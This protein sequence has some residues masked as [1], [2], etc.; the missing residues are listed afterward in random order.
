MPCAAG[1]LCTIPGLTPEAPI[2][3]ACRGGC[4]GR[5]HGLCGEVEDPDSDNPMHR[6]CHA[7]AAAKTSTKGAV[8]AP[9]GKRKSTDKEGRGTGPWKSAKSGAG[10]SDKSTSRA[11]LTLDQK[12]EI[13][14]LLGQGVTHNTIAGRFKCGLRTVSRV[15]EERKVLEKMAASAASKGGSK[16]NRSGDFPKVRQFYRVRTVFVLFFLV[17]VGILKYSYNVLGDFCCKFGCLQQYSTRTTVVI[18][19]LQKYTA[20]L[21][22]VVCT[23]LYSTHSST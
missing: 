8:T 11:R 7:C 9:A 23:D 2:G 12:L 10:K 22:L 14:Q 5:L 1:E 21:T 3:H 19:E 13:L 18:L 6:I 16:T 4:G 15:Q 17:V 20:V